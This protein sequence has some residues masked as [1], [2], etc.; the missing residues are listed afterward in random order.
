MYVGNLIGKQLE[1][2]LT[3]FGKFNSRW[4][5][6]SNEKGNSNYG[7]KKSNRN[8]TVSLLELWKNDNLPNFETREH[9]FDCS[10]IMV[11]TK[12]GI[13]PCLRG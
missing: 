11:L 4:I 3:L 1:P 6:E 10:V 8:K 12:M 7:E 13:Y 5:T 2:L 9:H